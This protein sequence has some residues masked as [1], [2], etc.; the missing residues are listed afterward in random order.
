MTFC[1]IG[2]PLLN[3]S[4]SQRN[5]ALSHHHRFLISFA[6]IY[7]LACILHQIV[8]SIR[9]PGQCQEF[10]RFL[11]CGDFDCA[12]SQ[13]TSIAPE[14]MTLLET[15]GLQQLASLPTPQTSQHRSNLLDL[16]VINC[17]I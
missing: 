3:L 6:I 15:H 10:D 17:Q 9:Q 16:V 14:L 2:L 12:S 5:N 1:F 7:Q 8:I 13:L 4:H 11:W